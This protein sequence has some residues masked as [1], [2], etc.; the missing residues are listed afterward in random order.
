MDNVLHS[1][2]KKTAVHVFLLHNLQTLWRTSLLHIRE[3]A[4]FVFECA[5][6]VNVFACARVCLIAANLPSVEEIHL[7]GCAVQ[8]FRYGNKL[9]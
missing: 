5:C 1:F 7:F 2:I 3:I 8:S 4:T 6:V 9:D